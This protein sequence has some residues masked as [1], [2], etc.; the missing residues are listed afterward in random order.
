M[1]FSTFREWAPEP[2]RAIRVRH[3]RNVW[4]EVAGRKTLPTEGVATW[5]SYR[6]RERAR[7]FWALYEPYDI[8]RVMET[9]SPGIGRGLG[10]HFCHARKD[11]DGEASEA[12]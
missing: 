2:L 10:V 7:A 4:S 3:I 5:K 12:L 8:A 6:F 1:L 9:R 11:E